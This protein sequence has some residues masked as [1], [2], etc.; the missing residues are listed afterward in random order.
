MTYFHDFEI[1]GVS[2]ADRIGDPEEFDAAIGKIALNFSYLEDTARNIIVLLSKADSKVGHIMTAELSFRQKI[3]VLASLVRHL[4]PTLSESRDGL[5]T[6]EVQEA[7]RE[8]LLVGHRAEELR[9][10]YLHSSYAGLERSKFSAK[11]KHG[12]RV[13]REKVDPALLLDV[14]DFIAT[15]GMDLEGLPLLLDL[16][17]SVTGGADFVTYS[18]DGTVLATFEFGRIA[19]S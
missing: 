15:V 2:F 18:K 3:D 7:L 12:L 1:S 5:S 14:A 11:A 8:L 17:D 6:P 4:L 9:N 19:Q 16:A 13:H 10:T